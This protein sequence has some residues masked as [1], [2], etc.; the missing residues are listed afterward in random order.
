MIF[1]MKD[2]S[3]VFKTVGLFEE[4]ESPSLDYDQSYVSIGMIGGEGIDV[5]RW[6]WNEFVEK[7][8]LVDQ[9]MKKSRQFYEERINQ[10][11]LFS[12]EEKKTL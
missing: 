7:V 4:T 3:R 1:E 2:S 11:S 9:E 5:F 8:N 10:M 12:E 6:E